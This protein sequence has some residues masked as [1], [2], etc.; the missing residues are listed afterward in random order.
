MD[1][2][3]FYSRRERRFLIALHTI[4]F[5]IH[6]ASSILSFQKA[7]QLPKTN[8]NITITSVDYKVQ[9]PYMEETTTILTQQQPIYWI[10]W[11]ETITWLAHIDAI[12]IFSLNRVIC[13]LNP[14][15]AES[16]R[17]WGSYA[18]TAGLLQVAMVLSIG[19]ASVFLITYLLVGNAILQLTG[20]LI[21][22]SESNKDRILY[23]ILGTSI[24]AVS[25]SFVAIRSFRID[26]L[27]F[28][29]L[30]VSY[31]G[32]AVIYGLFYS[33]FGIVQLLRQLDQHCCCI[34]KRVRCCGTFNADAIFVLLSITSKVFLSWSL[35]GIIESALAELNI[36]DTDTDWRAI[37]IALIVLCSLVLVG[38]TVFNGYYFSH[39][40]GKKLNN[41]IY[42]PVR[43][44]EF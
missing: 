17:R 3:K 34:K 33:S 31:T 25:V 21:D 39:E 23:G 9:P 10:A 29:D 35:I 2:N 18:I 42:R 28:D 15:V 13:G 11:N 7:N 30:A 36:I 20:W 41:R 14:R 43:G 19:P 44:I 4:A 37:Q 12:L 32:L 27:Q 38:G 16:T 5:F 24:F 22:Q 26:G 8:A 6:M 40:P 1:Q